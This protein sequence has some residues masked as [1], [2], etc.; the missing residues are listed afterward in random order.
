ME[1]TVPAGFDYAGVSKY[2]AQHIPG[3]DVPLSVSLISGGKSNVTYK[4]SGGDRTWVLRRPPLGHLLPTAH[5]MAR[6]YRVLTALRDTGVPVPRTIVLCEDAEVTGASFYVMD[7]VDGVILAE[8]IPDGFADTEAERHEIGP[9]IARTL[10]KLHAVDYNAV[11][12]GDFGRP[13]GYLERQVRRWNEQWERTKTRPLADV[14]EVVRRLKMALP[15]SPT[16]TIVHGDY[17]LGNMILDRDNPSHIKA[18][19]DW[20]MSTLGDPLSDLGYTLLYWTEAGDDPAATTGGTI[21][22]QPGFVNR[23]AIIDEYAKASGRDVGSVDY[24]VMFA[25]YKLAIICEGIH[26]R[27]LNGQ[28]VG[29]GFEGYG[30]RCEALVRRALSIAESSSDP[31]LRGA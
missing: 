3:G 15:A 27:F 12:L 24:Y 25:A 7:Y 6:E 17:R 9:S 28:T 13:E 8:S 5:D 21:T 10:A 29:E 1:T 2:F 18:L 31:K 11:G 22:T 19:L 26:Y 4:V 14:D 30:E 16:P 20:E 23:Q